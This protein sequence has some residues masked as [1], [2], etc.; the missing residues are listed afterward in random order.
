[1]KSH[2]NGFLH[3]FA[4]PQQAMKEIKHLEKNQNH[5]HQYPEIPHLVK[6]FQRCRKAKAK[7]EGKTDMLALP[8]PEETANSKSVAKGGF[9]PNSIMKKANT[10]LP[11]L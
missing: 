11:N 6:L 4:Y 5:Q 9:G 7:S 8:A 1:M 2:W 3:A 10:G